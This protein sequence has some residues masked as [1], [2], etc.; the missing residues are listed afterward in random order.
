MRANKVKQLWREGKASVGS[1]MNLGSPSCAEIMSHLGFDW[2]AVDQEHSPVGMETIQ[3][4]FVALSTSETVP[5][6]RVSANDPSVINRA[7]DCGAYGVIVPMVN[8]R[9]DTLR[10]VQACRYPPMGARSMGFGRADQYAGK[11]YKA[12]ANEEIALVVQIE[13]I[14]AVN[15]IDEILTVPGVDA[16]FIGPA[17]LAA[18]MGVP[19]VLGDN[20]DPR[21][22]E[23][24][25]KI[26]AAGKKHGI[27]AGIHVA[28][29]E[30]ANRRINE[31]F[32]F[33][34]L[35]TDVFFLT[36]AARAAL[37]QVTREAK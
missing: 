13:H 4:I 22:Q 18:S 11:D 29:A 26:V 19:V 20:P 36:G 8:S 2:I 16:F 17:D 35:G 32:R 14:D 12:H 9:D 3:H 6:I 15:N 10:A 27:P 1:W 30:D 34:A 37:A 23:A 24:V 21:H 33:V 5:M 28:T 25:R 7:L 31:G